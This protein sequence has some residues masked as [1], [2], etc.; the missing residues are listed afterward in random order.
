MAWG[1]TRCVG[2]WV[3]VRSD[4]T[5]RYSNLISADLRRAHLMAAAVER[6]RLD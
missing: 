3:I 1:S 4:T 6:M 2:S 5:L